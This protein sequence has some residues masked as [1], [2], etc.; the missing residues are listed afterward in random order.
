MSVDLWPRGPPLPLCRPFWRPLSPPMSAPAPWCRFP[1]PWRTYSCANWLKLICTHI[2][3]WVLSNGFCLCECEFMGVCGCMRVY[4][5]VWVCMSVYQCVCKA[6]KLK[7]KGIDQSNFGLLLKRFRWRR[8]TFGTLI[9]R[10]RLNGGGAG[11]REDSSPPNQPSCRPWHQPLHHSSLAAVVPSSVHQ[12]W[13]ELPRS[14]A[15]KIRINKYRHK[16]YPQNA[17]CV[18]GWRVLL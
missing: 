4:A 12:T 6:L 3:L 14:H 13:R 17:T 9:G 18:C 8:A 2:G 10:L 16:L 5:G 1:R 7:A 11:A 15:A